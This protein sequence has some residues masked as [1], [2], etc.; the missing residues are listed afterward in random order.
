MMKR[1]HRRYMLEH[2]VMNVFRQDGCPVFAAFATSD[3]NEVL[4]EIN[5][6]NA[7]TNTFAPRR[8]GWVLPPK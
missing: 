5:I 1:L 7:Q 3:K 4:T 6:L 8:R 2:F